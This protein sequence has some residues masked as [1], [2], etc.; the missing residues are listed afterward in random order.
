MLFPH[1]V[2]RQYNKQ[3]GQKRD[4]EKTQET[5]KNYKTEGPK[6]CKAGQHS[7]NYNNMPSYDGYL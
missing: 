3:T 2:Q 1:A 4:E 6:Q 5:K 7:N